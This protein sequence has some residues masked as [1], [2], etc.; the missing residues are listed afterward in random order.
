MKPSLMVFSALPIIA[1]Y[2]WSV[3]GL[4]FI[5]GSGWFPG[6]ALKHVGF[7]FQVWISACCSSGHVCLLGLWGSKLADAKG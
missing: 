2:F 6:S 1:T 5:E 7:A 3:W 4:T